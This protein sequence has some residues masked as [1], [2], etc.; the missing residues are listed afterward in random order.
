MNKIG[1]KISG[2]LLISALILGGCQ[3]EYLDTAPSADVSESMIFET[4]QG[5]M[6]ALNGTY[7]SMWRNLTNHGNFGQ[8][9]ADLVIDLMGNDMV[10][11]SRGYGWFTTE[12]NF[13]A[14]Q[15]AATNSRSERTWFFYYRTI[16]NVNRIIAGLDKA[17]GTPEEKDYIKGNALAL[18]AHAYFYLANFFQ[19]TYKGNESKPG[20][21]V[22]TEP[23]IVGKGRG[24]VQDVYNQ[25]I[26]DLTEAETLLEGKTKKHLSHINQRVVRGLRARVAL[27]M[28]DYATAATY[29]N[30]AK[31]DASALMTE[32]QYKAGF[33]KPNSEWIWGL[34]VNTEQATIFASLYSHFDPRTLSYAQLGLQKKI[35]KE[36]YD[37]I[38]A[39][40][41]RKE[42]FQTPG[43]ATAN[44]PD[45]TSLK[46]VLPLASN[47]AG[48]YLLMRAGEIYLIEAEALARS[49]NETAAREVLEA[50]V[51]ARNPLYTA[52]LFTGDALVNEIL[53]QRRI[54]LWGEGFGYLDLKRL[55][56]PLQ[57]PEGE[58]NHNSGLAA[59]LEMPAEDARFLMR[60]P[61]DEIN[62]NDNINAGDQ[63][64]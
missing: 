20:V 27:Q 21:P 58:G 37:Q 33:S 48:D 12:Y 28:E 36:L 45:Y 18:R 4:T 53:L 16:N 31:G 41:V 46:L 17:V 3:K 34:E 51:K 13:S 55:K 54:E 42:V 30:L 43:T 44:I 25:I 39:G 9:S 8:K 22:Y 52:A 15:N 29:A 10:I 57:R 2:L 14:L 35:T 61:Q 49:S 11:H 63:N 19:H 6:V 62:T 60:I 56:Q 47:W 7:R 40:D 5:A 38:P 64:P 1:K 50:L 59:I 32:D 26:S 23:T 24:T